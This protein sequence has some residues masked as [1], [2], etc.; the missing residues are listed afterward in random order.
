MIGNI[1]LFLYQN[2]RVWRMFEQINEIMNKINMRQCL[3][4]A[5]ET[6]L[7]ARGGYSTLMLTKN[8]HLS[9]KEQENIK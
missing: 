6:K 4:L 8:I 1:S 7:V 5:S 2:L 9:K 3:A